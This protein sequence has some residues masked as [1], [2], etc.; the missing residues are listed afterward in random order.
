M[1]KL[2]FYFSTMRAFL[3]LVSIVFVLASCTMGK[4]STPTSQ[5]T[6]TSPS[7]QAAP[8]VSYTEDLK[9]ASSKIKNT[10]EFEN[11][12]K[13]SVNMCLNQVGNELARTQKSPAICDELM[14]QS[15]KDSCKF[16]VVMMQAT[17]SKDIKTC[18]TLNSTYKRECRLA[19]LRNQAVE[20]KSLKSCDEMSIEFASVSGSLDKNMQTMQIDQCKLNVLQ[21]NSEFSAEDCMAITDKS[22]LSMCESIIKNRPQINKASEP[23]QLDTETP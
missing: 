23:N 1:W 16:G 3:L 17:E 2:S 19:I 8:A 9:N 20:K 11:C 12:M 13:P 6:S 21:S 15:S 4:T 10:S 22:M 18:D 7:G 14:D 5:N